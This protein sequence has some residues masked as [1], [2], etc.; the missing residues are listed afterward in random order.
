ML[1]GISLAIAAFIGIIYGM[2]RKNKTSVAVSVIVLII[3]AIIWLVY[4]YLYTLN[5]Y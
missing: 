1:L 2:V 4:S 5:P 3:I